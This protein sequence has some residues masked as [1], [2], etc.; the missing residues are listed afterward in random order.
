VCI[1]LIRNKQRAAGPVYQTG[2]PA[3]TKGTADIFT[4]QVK[5]KKISIPNCCCGTCSILNREQIQAI[6]SSNYIIIEDNDP[7][8]LSFFGSELVK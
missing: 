2:A 4:Y 7:R 5:Y 8:I 6:Y 1:K 3:A